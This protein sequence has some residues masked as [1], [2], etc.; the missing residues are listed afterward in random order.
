MPTSKEQQAL[1]KLREEIAQKL[2]DYETK[3]FH[4]CPQVDKNQVCN[5]ADHQCEICFADSLI[6]STMIKDL[7]FQGEKLT[8]EQLTEN[9]LPE[10]CCEAADCTFESGPGG[11]DCEVCVRK[12]GANAQYAAFHTIGELMATPEH[13]S[14]EARRL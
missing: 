4:N 8:D 12:L 3:P 6:Q 9:A 10:P 7:C 2:H 14:G 5:R 13:L 1:E 11:N